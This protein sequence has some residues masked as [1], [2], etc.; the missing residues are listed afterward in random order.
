MKNGK[1]WKIDEVKKWT[2]LKIRPKLKIKLTLKPVDKSA[3]L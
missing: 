1:N 2:K 3:A